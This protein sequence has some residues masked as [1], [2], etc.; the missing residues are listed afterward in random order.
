MFN[1]SSCIA[2]MSVLTWSVSATADQRFD[3]LSTTRKKPDDIYACR[4]TATMLQGFE[5]AV[6]DDGFSFL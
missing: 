6:K 5:A 2:T 1:T 3:W 4:C